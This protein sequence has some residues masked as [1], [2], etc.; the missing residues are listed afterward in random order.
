MFRQ[1]NES[2]ETI[3]LENRGRVTNCGPNDEELVRCISNLSMYDLLQSTRTESSSEASESEERESA[4][5]GERSEQSELRGSVRKLKSSLK[6]RSSSSMTSISSNKSVRFASELTR[7]KRFDTSREPITIS[8]ETSPQLWA[9][10]KM[11]SSSSAADAIWFGTPE[12]C[13]LG[14]PLT[15]T[16]PRFSLSDSDTELDD[17][18]DEDNDDDDDLDDDENENDNND[19]KDNRNY[20]YYKDSE[21]ESDRNSGFGSSAVQVRSWMLRRTN[22]RRFVP[23]G[24]D[25][26]KEL[27][28]YLEGHNIKLHSCNGVQLSQGKLTGLIYVTN[29]NF[30]KFIEIKFTF[31]DWRDIHYVTAT[32]K[33]TVT[34]T[35]DEFQFV[36]N[37]WSFV[38]FLK[39]KNL[40]SQDSMISPLTIH[41]CCRYDVNGET[42]YDNNNYENYKVE[43]DAVTDFKRAPASI[44][45][46]P[47]LANL[48][49]F[50]VATAPLTRSFSSDGISTTSTKPA[51]PRLGRRFSEDTDFFNS[52]P[53]KKT[54]ATT[55]VTAV[56]NYTTRP[57]SSSER[58]Y[59]E[60][61]RSYCFYDP[62]SNSNSR[63]LS[64]PSMSSSTNV[65]TDT[66]L[67]YNVSGT[68][69][70]GGGTYCG[71]PSNNPGFVA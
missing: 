51:P 9:T 1:E 6:L 5:L 64:P 31:N 53:L 34:E 22:I 52:S 27:S 65:L 46:V 55:Q 21:T 13:G 45:N 29:L 36:I 50:N 57:W 59:D 54:T 43:L 67:S 71:V 61:I 7:V 3:T 23:V 19:D 44:N 56:Q 37:L 66:Y 69:Q 38:Y 68:N 17:D 70:N 60:L 15:K 28:G 2:V 18:E 10:D 58:D 48:R 63:V 12:M 8:N 30:E 26:G 4:E 49:L 62:N 33:R 39:L 47:K 16:I 40:I 35:V 14:L 25:L 20:N 24:L 11:E 42:Y 32:Y 41:L